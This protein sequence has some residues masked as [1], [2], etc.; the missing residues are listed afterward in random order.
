VFLSSHL[1]DEV[2]K[3][4]DAAAIVDRGRV[5]AQGPISELAGG[6][7][8]DELIIAVDDADLAEQ[9]LAG[10]P[11][12][13]ELHP[14]EG[15]LR[16]VLSGDLDTAAELNARLVRAGVGVS[17]LEPVRHSLEQRFL[18]VISGLRSPTEDQL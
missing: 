7:A 18:D 15:A 9:T 10:S 12:V 1:L 14:A 16:V 2:E 4:C 8:R 5:V 6:H 11:L 13:S 17:R 3:I